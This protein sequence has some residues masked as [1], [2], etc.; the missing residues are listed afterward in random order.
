MTEKV[1]D[2]DDGRTAYFKKGMEMSEK[3]NEGILDHVILS[4]IDKGFNPEHWTQVMRDSIRE[5][6][7]EKDKTI[8]ELRHQVAHEKRRADQL[9][10]RTIDE[11]QAM[12]DSLRKLLSEAKEALEP[13][14]DKANSTK[15]AKYGVHRPDGTTGIVL[16]GEIR[17]C[18]KARKALASIKA[19][20]WK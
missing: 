6:L 3:T 8:E 5:A 9:H 20:E 12:I 17:D 13:F 18:I 10:G 7:V 16:S 4:A 15:V 14:A 19:T 11:Q 1:T 2:P